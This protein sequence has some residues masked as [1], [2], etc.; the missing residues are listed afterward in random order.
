MDRPTGSESNG[1]QIRV[2]L[3]EDDREDADLV[4]HALSAARHETFV[5]EWVDRLVPGLD[6]LAEG[7]IDVC[8]LDLSLPDSRGPRTVL[9]T[10]AQ[11]PDVPIVVLASSDGDGPAVEAAAGGT[12]DY[13]V[14]TRLDPDL[15]ARTIRHAIE[16]HEGRPQRLAP[17][18]PIDSLTNLLN[19]DGLLAVGE[20]QVRVSSVTRRPFALL[21]VDVDGLGRVNDLAGRRAGDRALLDVADL[22]A[23]TFRSSDLIA[24]VTGD[25]FCVILSEIAPNDPGEEG[26]R[27][28]LTRAVDAFNAHRDDPRR[29]SLTIGAARFDPASPCSFEELVGHAEQQMR[30]HKRR[31]A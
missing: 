5:V 2:L 16:A 28:R 12:Q 1:R 3:I 31:A 20:C 29:L 22:L 6:R 9:A 21:Y 14:K 4:R 25:E 15:V 23:V 17:G 8:L 13:L 11:A 30:E 24:R 18:P 7:G 26:A 10:R 27:D 19:G